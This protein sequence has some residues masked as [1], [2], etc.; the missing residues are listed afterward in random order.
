MLI[1]AFSIELLQ[2]TGSDDN[3]DHA[4]ISLGRYRDNIVIVTSDIA[5]DVI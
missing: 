1:L 4:N 2:Q 5:T 3:C